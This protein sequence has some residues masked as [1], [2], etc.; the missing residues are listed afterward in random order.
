MKSSKQLRAGR[1]AITNPEDWCKGVGPPGRCM[2][3]ALP[4][5]GW[6]QALKTQNYLRMVIKGPFIGDWNDH[7]RTTHEDVLLAYD[8]AIGIAE[9]EGD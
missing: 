6:H 7:K 3:G 2:L 4:P 1:E 8:A 5:V 9:A